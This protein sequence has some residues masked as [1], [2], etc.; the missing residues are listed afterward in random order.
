MSRR[1][2][3]HTNPFL[4]DIEMAAIE[5]ETLFENPT[6]PLDIEI[7][8]GK[9]V[10]VEQYAKNNP[11]RNIIAFEI[12]KQVVAY[13][14]E[15]FE[16]QSLSNIKVIHGAGKNG[17]EAIQQKAIIEKVFVFHPD[18]WLK[19]KHHKRRV[20]ND[21]LLML[22]YE[23]LKPEGMCYVSTDVAEL[24][25]S[26][27]LLLANHVDKYEVV[28]TD[29]WQKDYQTHWSRFVI[30]EKKDYFVKAFKKIDLRFSLSD[31]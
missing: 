26:V 27:D 20:L 23:K 16:A 19:K 31:N 9:G 17:I 1:F 13:L 5:P 14:R 6:H 25:Q 29:F 2:R 30:A 24:M 18:P 15:R 12:R 8:S 21:T 4:Y 7:G 11:N 3:T 28:E 10:F 22:L